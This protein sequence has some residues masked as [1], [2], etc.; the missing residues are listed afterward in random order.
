MGKSTAAR[1]YDELEL[2][3]FL[4]KIQAGHWYGRLA[5]T[6]RVTDKGTY[7]EA[8]TYDWR[9]WRPPA[10]GAKPEPKIQSPG[11]STGRSDTS[12]VPHQNRV[13]EI[14]AVP[15]PVGAANRPAMGADIGRSYS[16]MLQPPQAPTAEAPRDQAIANSFRDL[17]STQPGG[18]AP[19]T[20]RSVP[21]CFS[22]PLPIGPATLAARAEAAKPALPG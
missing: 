10:N 17:P 16:H 3:G 5:T 13:A 8:P 20:M 2:K 7:G 21:V 19:R 11:P 9:R 14:C 22:A 15:D 1:A 4:V 12:T 6:W 18:S